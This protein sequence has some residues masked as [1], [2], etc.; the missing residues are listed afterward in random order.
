MILAF[1]FIISSVF[2][3]SFLVILI[4]GST[5][6][7]FMQTFSGWLLGSMIISIIGFLTSFFF[8]ITYYHAS[9]LIVLQ[10]VL[11]ILL[12]LDIRVFLKIPFKK[13]FSF[14]IE[15]NSLLVLMIIIGICMLKYQ[16]MIFLEFPET[17][18]SY[19]SSI[20]ETEHS[21]IS[22]ILYGV[23][24]HRK[25]PILFSDPDLVNQTFKISS[26]PY[27]Y[28]SYLI[29]LGLD[30]PS[31]SLIISFMNT[32][33]TVAAV[34]LISNLYTADKQYLII[35]LFLFNGGLSLKNNF[36]SG[37]NCEFDNVY[38]SNR[39]D[40]PI[41]P[42]F[43]FHLAISKFSSF[44]IPLAIFA[45]A[46]MQSTQKKD[47]SYY[48]LHILSGVFAAVIPSLL[49]SIGFFICA[50]NYSCSFKFIMPFIISL[51]PKLYGCYLHIFPV[52]REYQ[53]QGI[54]FSQIVSFT[55]AYGIIYLSA[56]A[57]PFMYKDIFH[58][59]RFLT[60]LASFL[61]LCFV[62]E[63]NDTFG[64]SIAISALFLPTL[65]GHFFK[66]FQYFIQKLK[67]INQYFYGCVN[68]LFVINVFLILLSGFYLL[69]RVIQSRSSGL[70]YSDVQC[71]KWINQHIN[72]SEIFLSNF[73]K[74]N[75]GVFFYG[76]QNYLGSI[77][78]H[79]KRGQTIDKKILF[80]EEFIRFKKIDLFMNETEIKYLLI[81]K[82]APNIF[83]YN[84]DN[85]L[86][87]KKNSKWIFLKYNAAD[88]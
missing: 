24:Y 50:S 61:F 87:I 34:F 49:T 7:F 38:N 6:F 72:Q 21:F 5:W 4:R 73:Q 12:L 78:E 13:I 26:L 88:L 8:P 10:L 33:S 57:L 69:T 59:H 45:T 20:I 60:C 74:L 65:T 43:P 3:G 58:F 41:Y 48:R 71:S 80:L 29:T 27:I 40:N 70:T 75:P 64:N 28:T 63:N 79:W 2:F 55:D 9:L 15:S 68:A 25:D 32:L 16:R 35:L 85:F 18:P 52:W 30:Y 1:L 44:S 77:N 84:K 14:R 31:A 17:F 37:K 81:D 23:N 54:F 66:M 47:N 82:S 53:M 36:Y 22:S 51:I 19:C 39:K 42:L 56:F 86:T 76:K 83:N 62:R 67:H 11:S 46:L